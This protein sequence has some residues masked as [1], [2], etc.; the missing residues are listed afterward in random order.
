MFRG[1]FEFKTI[2]GKPQNY[3]PGEIISFQG[4]HYQCIRTTTLSPLQ[5]SKYWK[6]AGNTE[7]YY[8]ENPPINPI[9]GQLWVSGAGIKYVWQKDGDSSQWIET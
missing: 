1:E 5:N 6:Y 4:K 2:S 9:V 3:F 7:V 8:S